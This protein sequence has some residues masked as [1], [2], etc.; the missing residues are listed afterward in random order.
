[1]CVAE[2]RRDNS[3]AQSSSRSRLTLLL[4]SPSAKFLT[5]P[6][7]FTVLHSNPVRPFIFFFFFSLFF[8]SPKRLSFPRPPPPRRSHTALI[9]FGNC[10]DFSSPFVSHVHS[11]RDCMKLLGG[12]SFF[13]DARF[14]IQQHERA[15]S[16]SSLWLIR[17]IA[18]S[19]G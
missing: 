7:F 5:S 2:L 1:M 13:S 8:L 12:F 14:I 19:S 18:K 10:K 11:L 17:C 15:P 9:V 3:V 4:Q 16:K 6:D